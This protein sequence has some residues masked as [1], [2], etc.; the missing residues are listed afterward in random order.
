MVDDVRMELLAEM[1]LIWRTP[2]MGLI[3][4]TPSKIEY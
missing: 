3:E 1:G 2:S 4:R